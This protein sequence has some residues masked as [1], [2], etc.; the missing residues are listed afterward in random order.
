MQLGVAFCSQVVRLQT[1]VGSEGKKKVR[2]AKEE[3]NNKASGPRRVET[4]RG[5]R[6]N[7]RAKKVLEKGTQSRKE[8]KLKKKAR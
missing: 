2:I 4:I 5:G 8:Y 1:T 6:G 3:N 7:E